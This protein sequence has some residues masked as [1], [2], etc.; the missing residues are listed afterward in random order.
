MPIGELKQGHI[1]YTIF[2]Y[3][4]KS[5][6]CLYFVTTKIVEFCLYF[7]TEGVYFYGL[8]FKG[9]ANKCLKLLKILNLKIIFLKSQCYNLQCIDY[10]N[11]H[12]NLPFKLLKSVLKYSFAFSLSQVC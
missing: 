7:E 11:F 10:T 6:F 2:K 8:L 9:L 1:W 12:K 5:Q 3:D 4:E